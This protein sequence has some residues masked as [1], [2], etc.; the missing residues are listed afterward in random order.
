VENVVESLECIVDAHT[1]LPKGKDFLDILRPL[2]LSR[3]KGAVILG[4]P[5]LDGLL[6]TVNLEDVKRE[7][8]RV[9]DILYRLNPDLAGVEPEELYL[10]SLKLASNYGNSPPSPPAEPGVVALAGVDLS[11]GPD[12]LQGVLERLVRE[13]FRGF[14]VISTLYMK[15]LDD[16]SVEAVFEAASYLGVPVVVHAGCDPGVWE[17]PAFCRYGDPSRLEGVLRRYRDVPTVIAHLGGYSAFAP[18]VFTREAVELARRYPNVYLDTSAVPGYLVRVAVKSLPRG[19]VV[20]GSD[21]PVVES[22]DVAYF[23]SI[24]W[25]AL[26]AAGYPRKAIDDSFHGIAEE[27][28]GVRCVDWSATG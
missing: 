17:L 21:Y 9:K 27:L 5:P 15:Y 22:V 2:S 24:V 18:G 12:D 11:L 13:G 26:A 28:F 20:F 25:R 10:S 23:A 19:K 6:G 7:H 3:Y 16:P 14:K 8:A 1:H 4:I